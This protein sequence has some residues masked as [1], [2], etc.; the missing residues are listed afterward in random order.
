[1]AAVFTLWVAYAA[2]ALMTTFSYIYSN[3]RKRR[4]KEPMLLNELMARLRWLPAH[5]IAYHPIGWLL[6]YVV[7]VLFIVSY[8][9]VRSY[10]GVDLTFLTLIIAGAIFG[11]IGI[12]GWEITF[13]LHPSPPP[14]IKLSEYYLQLFIAHVLFG[15][16]AFVGYYLLSVVL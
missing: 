4:F 9:I 14:D 12:V 16:G 6:H 13:R 1:M 15:I 7:G 3:I 8:E 10:T 2:I 5:T 11:V